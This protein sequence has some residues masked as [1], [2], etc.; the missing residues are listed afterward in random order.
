MKDTRVPIAKFRLFVDIQND[1][2]FGSQFEN[3]LIKELSDFH[4][5]ESEKQKAIDLLLFRKMECLV[6]ELY[7]D[8]SYKAI[9]IDEYG[10]STHGDIEWLLQ[11]GRAF[12]N[13]EYQDDWD[14]AEY[15]RLKKKFG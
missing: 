6:F 15:E 7:S 12:K 3:W 13:S 10:S 5:D 1:K 4:T 14:R 8:G 11:N 9:A 2:Y